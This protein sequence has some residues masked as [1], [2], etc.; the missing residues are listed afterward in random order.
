MKRMLGMMAVAAVVLSPAW[1]MQA[2]A[3]GGKKAKDAQAQPLATEIVA[4]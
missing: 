1:C 4:K 2:Q 3:A